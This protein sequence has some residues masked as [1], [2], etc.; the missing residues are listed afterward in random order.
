MALPTAVAAATT[1][2]AA[3]RAVE[4][5]MEIELPEI[6]LQGAGATLVRWLLCVTVLVIAVRLLW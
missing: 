2:V 1:F 4:G 5:P 6:S 3:V